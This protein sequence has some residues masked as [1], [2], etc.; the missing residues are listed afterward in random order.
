MWINIHWLLECNDLPN[1]L[2]FC[3]SCLPHLMWR[4]FFYYEEIWG[5]NSCKGGGAGRA[6]QRI[7][8][9]S[10]GHHI[11]WNSEQTCMASRTC[12]NASTPCIMSLNGIIPERFGWVRT[13]GPLATI[14]NYTPCN[15]KAWWPRCL[16]NT[17][18]HRHVVENKTQ[19][20][21]GSLDLQWPRFAWNQTGQ[22][23]MIRYTYSWYQW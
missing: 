20:R 11:Q 6:E 23:V 22:Y 15:M 10:F 12:I 9:C 13:D 4:T 8:K 7:S 1:L 3:N 5:P 18:V 2:C 14:C 17:C 21:P 16:V 19:S